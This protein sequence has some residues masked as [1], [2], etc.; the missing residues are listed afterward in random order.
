MYIV[1]ET[2]GRAQGW[3][4][5]GMD[6]ECMCTHEA[7]SSEQWCK[8]KEC[9]TEVSS[10]AIL[11]IRRNTLSFDSPCVEVRMM[12]KIGTHSSGK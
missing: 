8:V 6:D 11:K 2:M 10:S 9:K 4:T 5:G 3:T 7:V 1:D 12:I